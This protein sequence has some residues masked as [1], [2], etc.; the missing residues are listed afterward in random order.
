M[1]GI[2]CPK[3]ARNFEKQ[4]LEERVMPFVILSEISLINLQLGKLFY[5]LPPAF[6]PF[7]FMAFWAKHFF[8]SL[9]P[10]NKEKKLLN[11][12]GVSVEYGLLN[13][14]IVV[15]VLSDE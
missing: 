7:Q 12:A 2:W 14:P 9:N 10:S 1:K 5:K 3:K 13:W 15:R 11:S 4:V 6:F 8:T